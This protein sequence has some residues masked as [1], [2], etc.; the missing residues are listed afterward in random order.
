MPELDSTIEINAPAET[1]WQILTDFSRFPE[2]NPFMR[3]ASGEVKPGAQLQVYLQPSNASGMT[4][5]PTVLKA[6]PS[7]ELRWL[8]SLFVRGLFDG[9]HVLKIEPLDPNRV[10]FTQHENFSGILAPLI[11]SFIGKDT[12]RGFSEMNQALKARA[13][14]KS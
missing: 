12:V 8:G 13:E 4:F 9:E 5:R 14:E 2:W 11:L 10:R 1:V 6:E 7:R 3:R